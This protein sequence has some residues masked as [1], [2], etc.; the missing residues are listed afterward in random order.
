MW[1]SDPQNG[2]FFF[3]GGCYSEAF[4]LNVEHGINEG[5][6]TL[7]KLFGMSKL[8]I[9]WTCGSKEPMFVMK[10]EVES[11]QAYNVVFVGKSR[12]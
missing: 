7:Q 11:R 3:W 2:S 5:D 12:E 1:E 4:F 6:L 8:E 10:T 9:I